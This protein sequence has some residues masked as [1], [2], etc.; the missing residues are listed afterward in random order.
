MASS[1]HPPASSDDRELPPPQQRFGRS[2]DE[3]LRAAMLDALAQTHLAGPLHLTVTIESDLVFAI[4]DDGPGLPVAPVGGSGAADGWTLARLLSVD[5]AVEGERGLRSVAAACTRVLADSWHAGRH[6][7]VERT[8]SGVVGEPIEVGSTRQ[9]G[10][11]LVFWLDPNR[12]GSAARLSGLDEWL[13][14]ELLGE[15]GRCQATL[16]MHDLRVRHP[17]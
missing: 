11:R 8:G 1:G 17:V 13:S 5:P 9:R 4:L 15:F 7:R 16:T 2:P 10:S 3:L 6:H 12:F 14:P